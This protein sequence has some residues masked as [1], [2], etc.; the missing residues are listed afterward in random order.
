MDSGGQYLDGTIDVT[1]TFHYGTP[2]PEVI[3][4]YTRVLLGHIDLARVVVPR[5][6]IDRGLDLVSRQHIYEK[7][8]DYR[9]RSDAGKEN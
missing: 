7:G 8:L 6:T 5:G 2:D 9:F 3:E 1:R 4:M